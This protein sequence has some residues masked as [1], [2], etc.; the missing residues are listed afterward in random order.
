LGEKLILSLACSFLQLYKGVS[1]SSVLTVK[2]VIARE[3]AITIAAATIIHWWFP[4][5]IRTSVLS[6]YTESTASTASP[7]F[8]PCNQL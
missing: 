7:A 4:F 6:S 1:T 3:V 2:P 5:I 8:L